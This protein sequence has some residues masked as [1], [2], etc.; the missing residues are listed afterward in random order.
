MMEGEPIVDLWDTTPGM[1]ALTPEMAVLTSGNAASAP[2]V[3]SVATTA[4]ETCDILVNDLL[5]KRGF[6]AYAKERRSDIASE[7][8][9]SVLVRAGTA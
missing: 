4:T 1:K 5:V 8:N 3:S 7:T 2:G 6:A 9:S